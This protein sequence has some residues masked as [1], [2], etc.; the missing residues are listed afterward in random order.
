ASVLLMPPA[1][2]LVAPPVAFT[3]V[4]VAVVAPC[5]V[6]GNIDII[7]PTFL[8]EIDRLT[9]RIVAVAMLVPVLGMAGRHM[10]VDRLKGHTH[11]Y[12]LDHDRLR[13]EDGRRC[14][15]ADVNA[16]IE[17]ELT[18]ADRHASGGTHRQ[19]GGEDDREQEALHV[20]PPFHCCITRQPIR[21]MTRTVYWL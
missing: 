15:G 14:Q 19:N 1:M 6:M 12:R 10:Q 16:A 9:T 3:I 4:V 17:A 2:S 8:H 7:V 11:W 21:S 5:T 20:V 13:V 18:N